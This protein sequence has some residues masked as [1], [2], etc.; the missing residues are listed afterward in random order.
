LGSENQKKKICP[1]QNNAENTFVRKFE[2]PKTAEYK[3][4]NPRGCFC[5]ITFR[6]LTHRA[7]RAGDRNFALTVLQSSH[8]DKL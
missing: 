2:Q 8:T 1:E 7:H 4:P 5:L 6:V 3:Q